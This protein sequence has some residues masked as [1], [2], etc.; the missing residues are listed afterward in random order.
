MTGTI[1]EKL[2]ESLAGPAPVFCAWV[3]MNEPAAAEALAREAFD[4]VILDM[5]HGALDFAGA[6]GGIAASALA[7]RPAIVRVPVGEFATASRALDAG[8]AGVIAPMINS[9]ADAERFAAFTKFPPL[10]ERSWGPRG[11]LPLSGLDTQD[12]LAS[13]N[14]LVRAIAMIET[15]EA[16]AALDAILA[17]PGI[18]GVFVGPNDLSIGLSRGDAIAPDGAEVERALGEVAARAA[19]HG[20]FAGLF[21]P[22]GRRAKW[23]GE[24]G[25][26]LRTV[27]T[28]LALLRAAARAELAAAR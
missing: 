26:A 18:D 22:D 1:V 14:R 13:A 23:A 16:L 9:R 10:G 6:C 4:A 20:K 28:D 15:R 12:Y 2:L 25:F 27:S 5:Q 21:C 7:G 19:A 11:A 24:R 8:A 3:G 17:T